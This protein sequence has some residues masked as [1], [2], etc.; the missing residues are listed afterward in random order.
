MSYVLAGLSAA[1]AAVALL[2]GVFW[3]ITGAT[4]S[5]CA[6]GAGRLLAGQSCSGVV[7]MHPL[8]G[9]IALVILAA[10]VALA[11]QSART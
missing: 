10:A 6:S 9:W 4:Y 11:V 8:A 7:N 1:C 5:A 2:V 3:S